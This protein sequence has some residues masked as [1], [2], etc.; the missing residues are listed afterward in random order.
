LRLRLIEPGKSTQNA[1]IEALNGKF[2]IALRACQRGRVV[3]GKLLLDLGKKKK[4]CLFFIIT[5][6][7]AMA[8]RQRRM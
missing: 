6:R 4:G 3:D 2:R 7:A 5:C 8:A 1:Y